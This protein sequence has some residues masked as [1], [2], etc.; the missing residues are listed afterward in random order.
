MKR[1]T[2]TLL[3]AI[4]RCVKQSRKPSLSLS[5]CLESGSYPASKFSCGGN[6]VTGISKSLMHSAS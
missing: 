3:P 2:I 4:K 5:N 1:S 6:F